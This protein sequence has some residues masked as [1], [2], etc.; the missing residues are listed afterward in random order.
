MRSYVDARP[1]KN[2]VMTS[3]TLKFLL[4]WRSHRTLGPRSRW[5]HTSPTKTLPRHL[6]ADA[7]KEDRPSE[8]NWK[9]S[10]KGSRDVD[11]SSMKLP[12]VGVKLVSD[13]SG[14]TTGGV[15]PRH[16]AVHLTGSPRCSLKTKSL[17][18]KA[19]CASPY[20]LDWAGKT[21]TSNSRRERP[22]TE[23]ALVE[24]AICYLTPLHSCNRPRSSVVARTVPARK[25]LWLAQRQFVNM[26]RRNHTTT[27]RK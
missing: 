20:T 7:Q 12:S 1:S 21:I 2:A 11:G 14:E 5:F 13:L 17:S 25:A 4:S 9:V 23:E 16:C 27:V 22:S 26:S 6:A 24:T 10:S 15:W 8:R 3:A 19:L 18:E